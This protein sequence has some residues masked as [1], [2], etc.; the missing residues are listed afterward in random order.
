[1]RDRGGGVGSLLVGAHNDD[2]QLVYAGSV[3][4]GFTA[5]IRK[6]LSVR[7][8]DLTCGASPFGRCI[9][10]SLWVTPSVVVN[11]DY[12]EFNRHLRHP[13]LKGIADVDAA[14]AFSPSI[15]CSGFVGAA[16]SRR[17][18]TGNAGLM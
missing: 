4:F 15:D 11:V 14:S 16:W 9:D 17:R 10:G 6:A 2:G 12:R 1:L 7:F 18:G 8:V 13:S 5:Q 3:G